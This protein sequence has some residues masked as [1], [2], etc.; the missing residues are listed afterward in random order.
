MA[1]QDLI[2]GK[3]PT[4]PSET[5]MAWDA[6]APSWAM[7][8]TLLGGTKAMRNAGSVYLPQHPEESAP[9][10]EE[11]L[12]TNVL[13]NAMELTL[14]H[15]VGRPFSDPVRLNADVPDDIA[16]DLINIDL[17]GNDI[18][19]FCRE[20]FRC[21]LAKG[22]CHVMVDVP[23]MNPAA[24]PQ[25]LAD[26]KASGRRPFWIKIEPENMIAADAHV[27][28]DPVS[29]ELR[30][31]LTHV[32]LRENIIQRVGFAEVMIERIRVI[33]PGFFQVWEKVK[34]KGKKDEWRVIE[35]G[36]TGIDFIPIVTFYSQRD[37]FLL[38]KPPLEDLA[39]LNIRHW[40]SMSDQI[41]VLTVA[42]F[43]MLAVAGAT[44]QAGSAMAIGPR[45]LLATKDPNGRFYY[46]EHTGDS[47]KAGWDEIDKLEEDMEAY[48]ATFLKKDPGNETATG[49]ALDSAESVTPLQDMITRFIDSVNNCLRIHATW[50]GQ[51]DG[52]TVTILNDFG[53]E[54]ADKFGI[55]LLKA[56]RQDKDI[57]RKAVIKEAQRLGVLTDEYDADEDFE[58]L[59]LEDKELKPLQPQVP[60]TFDPSAPD[61][62]PNSESPNAKKVE[63]KDTIKP[64][65]KKAKPKKK[66]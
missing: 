37:G 15:F 58:Q 2:N 46:V 20:W 44:D 39:F 52:G 51:K 18:T 17:Q 7:I 56:M 6:M 42:R 45:Q 57:S 5:S 59:K 28:V 4:D 22:F 54:D 21:G 40:Q 31:V 62:A 47:I 26:D 19:T 29:K 32:R 25:T 9:N 13:F 55:D 65:T 14:D 36:E 27:L 34:V 48:G 24:M 8:E 53:P 41:N 10:Y 64:T 35:T 23:Q 16:E 3:D 1:K 63:K 30:E 66:E 49:R 50:M 11:R 61:G 43:P 12:L 38:A 60:G 33:E